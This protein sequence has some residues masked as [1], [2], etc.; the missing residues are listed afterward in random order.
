MS[1]QHVG[2]PE[3]NS[4]LRWQ[5]IL[6]PQITSSKK[7]KDEIFHATLNLKTK[8]SPNNPNHT[9]SHLDYQEYRGQPKLLKTLVAIWSQYDTSLLKYNPI[10]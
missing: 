1:T 6:K 9:E 7:I 3:N 8:F 10:F 4:Q 2:F 5:N